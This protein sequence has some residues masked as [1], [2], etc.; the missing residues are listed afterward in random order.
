MKYKLT[1][2]T[3]EVFGITLY[4]IQA[5]KDFTCVKKGEIGGWI[6]SERNLS[7][8]GDAWV[9]GN[10]QVYGNARVFGDAQVFGNARVYGDAQV[11]GNAR[12]SG[13]AQV[14]G[15]AWVSGDARVYGNARV[16]GNARVFGDAQ[17][18]GDAWVFGNARV[19]QSFDYL[20]I[21]PIG[22]RESFT[23]FYRTEKGISV[24]CGCFHGTLDEFAFKVRETHANNEHGKTYKAAINMAIECLKGE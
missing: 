24:S 4:R 17:V 3:K 15:D 6:E 11:Y 10:A 1:E 12:V 13:D 8:N 19:K 18:Y 22:S 20:L 2:Q 14:F 21:G 5:L 16:S 23:T 7:Q 9:S